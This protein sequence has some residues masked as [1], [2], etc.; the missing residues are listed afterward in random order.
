MIALNLLFPYL[1]HAQPHAAIHSL[2]FSRK[3]VY[4]CE[5]GFP[6]I[7]RTIN[8]LTRRSGKRKRVVCI[9]S[10]F[11]SDPLRRLLMFVFVF[12]VNGWLP[13]NIH[14]RPQGYDF[15]FWLSGCPSVFLSVFLSV[16]LS[17]C[18]SICMY[19]SLSNCPPI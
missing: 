17:V 11:P 3:R 15:N 5:S 12:L 6:W 16:C 18:L 10:M 2:D 8:A 9:H 1:A 13:F 7:H 19:R 4:R 14:F